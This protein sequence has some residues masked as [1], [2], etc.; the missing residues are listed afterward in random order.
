[1]LSEIP[2]CD[3]TVF[4]SVFNARV[5]VVLARHRRRARLEIVK[6]A[7]VGAQLRRRRRSSTEHLSFSHAYALRFGAGFCCVYFFINTQRA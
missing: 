4:A 6:Y 3:R 7:C 2:E 5:S 1:M